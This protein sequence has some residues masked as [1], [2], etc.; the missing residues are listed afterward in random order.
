M[1]EYANSVCWYAKDNA[2]Y[3]ED[4][5]KINSGHIFNIGM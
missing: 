5:D 2:K 3:V 1:E 4:Y